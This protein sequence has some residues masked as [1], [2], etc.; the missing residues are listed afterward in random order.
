MKIQ[1]KFVKISIRFQKF[2][3]FLASKLLDSSR[4][5]EMR[6][7]LS[8]GQRSAF[9]RP[10]DHI[11]PLISRR[12]TAGKRRKIKIAKIGRPLDLQIHRQRA[13]VSFL[14]FFL[15]CILCCIS[16]ERIWY[17][18]QRVLFLVVNYSCLNFFS[19]KLVY[20]LEAHVISCACTR[21]MI[22]YADISID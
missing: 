18:I 5:P 1:K 17:L 21:C 20:L 9:E 14:L 19:H 3:F 10:A 22:S 7:I 8:R 2:Q 15:P 13:A 12:R 4:R 11:G 6:I 16:Y